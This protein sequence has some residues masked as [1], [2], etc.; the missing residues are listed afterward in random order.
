[1]SRVSSSTETVMK[2]HP[3]EIGTSYRKVPT[4]LINQFENTTPVYK[5]KQ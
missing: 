1:V 3:E 4:E 5:I 2:D